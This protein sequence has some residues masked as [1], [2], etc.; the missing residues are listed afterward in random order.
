MGFFGDIVKGLAAKAD[1]VTWY[2]DGCHTVLND[3]IGFNTDS[4]SWE[5]EKCGYINDV[6]SYNIYASEE[7]YQEQLGIPRCPECDGMV[8]G[9]APDAEHWFICRSCGTKYYLEGGIL[10]DPLVWGEPGEH[11]NGRICSNCG[12]SL[13]H[14]SY[15]SAWENGNNSDGYWKCPHCGAITFDY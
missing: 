8:E 5:C 15:T 4:G 14:A 13:A 1:F 2:C 7:S 3:Q 9:T 10:K 12:G 6:N 11:D